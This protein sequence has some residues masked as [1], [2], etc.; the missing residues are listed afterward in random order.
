MERMRK[1]F[2][3]ACGDKSGFTLVEIIAV[4]VILGILAAVA[5]PRYIDLQASA[6]NRAIDA[7]IAELNARENLVWS[8]VKLSAGGWASDASVTGHTDYDTNL[9]DDYTVGANSITFGG[10]T[11]NTTRSASTL[12]SP[13]FWRRATGGGG[14]G[15][16]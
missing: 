1:M 7:G 6:E 14:G 4:L 2:V 10:T 16:E 11:V 9:G 8:D 13:G 5:I 15:G 12:T 3:G